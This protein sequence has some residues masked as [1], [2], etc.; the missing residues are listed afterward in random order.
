MK[1]GVP[2]E[3][4]R[5]EY[6]VGMTPHSVKAYVKSGHQV[7]VEKGAGVGSG[8]DDAEYAGAGAQMVAD[9]AELFKQSEMI[10]KVKEPL[11][12]EYSLFHHGQILYT[13]LH[14]A[15]SKDLA[16]ALIQK[17]IT[18]VAYETIELPDHSLPCLTPMSEIAG[19]LSV[20]EGAKYLEKEFGGRGILLGGVPGV[21]RGKVG[22]LGGGVVGTNAC[23]IAVG[24]GANVTVLDI[25]AKRLAYLDDIFGSSITT[26]YA[27]EAN[28]EYVLKESDIVI[29]AVL[30]A[31]ETAPRLITRQHLSI[32]Q[33]G[34]VIVDVAIDQ[35]GC[36]ETSRPTTHDDP[37][38]I[39]D[40]VVHYCVA[41]MPGAVARSSTIALTSVTLQYGLQIANQGL[42]AAARANEALRR[43]INTIDGMCVHPGVAKSCGLPYTEYKV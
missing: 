20:Q 37:I 8:Y 4:K 12:E 27:T 33:H 9:K 17:K 32:M 35:G 1:L 31:G 7:L 6:R 11:P 21:Q 23:K 29:G 36:A 30:V 18:G 14:L 42:R 43:G 19:R 15:A 38:Y 34:A 28:I 3:V 40:N 22:I 39:V 2:K 24:I 26:L 25:N 5:H 13:Y 41:N 16:N 10:V